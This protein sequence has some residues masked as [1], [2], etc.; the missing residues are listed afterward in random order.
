MRRLFALLCFVLAFATFARN[1]DAAERI[2]AP[3]GKGMPIPVR[4]AVYFADVESIEEN[5]GEFVGTVDLRVRWEDPR[6]RYPK[7]EAPRGFHDLRGEEAEA[8]LAEIWVPDVVIANV[9]DEPTSQSRGVRIWPD[10]KVELMQRTKGHFACS[11]DFERFPFDRQALS[12]ELVS[13]RE[14]A[15]VVVLDYRQEDLDF[16][17][18]AEGV[19][20]EGWTPG[21]VDFHREA[22]DGWYGESHARVW[23]ALQVHRKAGKTVPV[24]FVPLFASLFIPLLAMW[25]NK[26]EDGEFKVE[27]FELTNIVIGGL[28]AVIALNFTIGAEYPALAAADNTVS[29][30]FGL[31]YLA[32]A[33]SLIVNLVLFRFNVVQRLFGK[34]VQEQLYLVLMWA[35]P[36][37][38]IATATAFVLVAMA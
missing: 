26:V 5:D 27:A 15:E 7:Q 4:V 37:L 35:L 2:D 31:N 22:I 3:I 32:L 12:I 30:L 18:L 16:T 14:T 10:G 33:T 21:L 11:F 36:L 19:D 13:R 25:L 28:F 29:R 20:I 23:V 9:V 24:I 6:L 38:S 1:A 34:Y 8:K 17:R